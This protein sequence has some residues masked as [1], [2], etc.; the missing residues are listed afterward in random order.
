MNR[1]TGHVLVWD[2]FVRFFHWSLVIGF[3][4]AYCYTEPS[5]C[6]HQG[7]GYLALGLIAARTVWGFIATR[8]Y[9]R[10]ECVVPSPSRLR[11]HLSRLVRGH[12]PRHLGHSPAGAVLILFLLAATLFIGV[13]GFLI[14]TDPL[15]DNELVETLHVGAVDVTVIAVLLHVAA[16]LCGS[17]RHRE[18]LLTAMFTG[19]KRDYGT[20]ERTCSTGHDSRLDPH[21]PTH[22]NEV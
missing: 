10:F 20:Q 7:A 13:T 9:A 3:T 16:I 22:P 21:R 18:N 12:A 11:H 1:S 6:V 5:D 14:T 8:P 15:R 17:F 2:R 4:T 19:Y